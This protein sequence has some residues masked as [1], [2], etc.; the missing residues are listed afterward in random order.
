MDKNRIDELTRIAEELRRLIGTTSPEPWVRHEGGGN[1]IN[2]V[3][4]AAGRDI[5]HVLPTSPPG[6]APA[7][8]EFV[9]CARQNATELVDGV[10]QLID[11]N[12]KLAREVERLKAEVQRLNGEDQRRNPEDLTKKLDEM[13]AE[14]GTPP[15]RS[16]RSSR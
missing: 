16:L 7:N 3:V 9:T 14:G 12:D 13:F 10:H 11:E 4:L 2:S 15:R 1:G 8:A 5:L 6:H